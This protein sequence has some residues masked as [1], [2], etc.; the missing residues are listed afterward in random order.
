MLLHYWQVLGYWVFIMSL[1]NYC[2]FSWILSEKEKKQNM[3]NM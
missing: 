1:A 3:S 2:V